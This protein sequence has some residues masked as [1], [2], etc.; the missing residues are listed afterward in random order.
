MAVTFGSNATII[1]TFP[2]GWSS[3]FSGSQTK[4]LLQQMQYNDDGTLTTVWAFDGVS[5]VLVAIMWGSAGSPTTVPDAIVAAGYSQA[6]NNTDYNLF[7]STYKAT[8]NQ[9]IVL[10]V[11][12]S[13]STPSQ[14]TLLSG[15]V[16][17]LL[18]G[19]QPVNMANPLPITGS[20]AVTPSGVQVVTGSVIVANQ[21]NV[22]G[23]S[24]TPTITGSV[25]VSNTVNVIDQSGSVVGLLVGGQPVNANNAVPVSIDNVPVNLF[26]T[27]S[28]TML[29]LTTVIQ[30]SG[31][32]NPW[33][34]SG[35]SWTPTVTGSV[36]VSN[37]VNVI[38]QSGSIVGLSVGGVPVSSNNPVPIT[39]SISTTPSGVQTVT[40]SVVVANTVNV[41]DQ[42]GSLVGLLVGGVALSSNNPLPVTGTVAIAS[43]VAVTQGTSPWIVSGSAWTPTI[44][45]SVVVANTVN[46]VDQSGSVT[47]LLVGG[48]PVSQANQLPVT[49]SVAIVAGIPVGLTGAAAPTQALEVGGVNLSGNLTPVATDNAGLVMTGDFAYAAATGRVSGALAGAIF[50]FNNAAGTGPL[51][52]TTYNESSASIARQVSVAS[53]VAADTLG[54]VG[55]QK[56]TLTYYDNS[57]NG[58]YTETISLNGTTPVNS[59]GVNYGVLERVVVSQVGASGSNQGNITIYNAANG[60]SGTFGVIGYG[61]QTTNNGD[62]QSY[63]GTHYV[64][65]GKTC[66]ILGMTWDMDGVTSGYVYLKAQNPLASGSAGLQ[67]TPEF[68]ARYVVGDAPFRVPILLAGP[69]RVHIYCDAGGGVNVGAS[70]EFVEF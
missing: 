30:Y 58:P 63:W 7:W 19:G 32:T 28:I 10:P 2:G 23:S 42:S 50:S 12:I 59:V 16:T 65:P 66:Y 39:G 9:Q 47:G 27:A 1:Q 44:T 68:G 8:S 45:G 67:I 24:W 14:V 18:L 36:V 37:T 61:V 13:G 22:T 69:S 43:P 56:V 53:S 21:V 38:D 3:F 64:R 26:V 40:G 46:V 51:R 60:A 62:N 29:P 5:D 54:G 15:S 20:I 34:V 4:N 52:A 33:I 55:A 25:V 49:G 31:S 48:V 35:S 41:L 6:Q 11:T 70:F 57:L 17:G